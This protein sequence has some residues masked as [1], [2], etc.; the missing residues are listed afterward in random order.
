MWRTIGVLSLV[1]SGASLARADDPTADAWR[2]DGDHAIVDGVLVLGGKR[3]TRAYL[4]P[5]VQ[6]GFDICFEYRLEGKA[7]A[8]LGWDLRREGKVIPGVGLRVLPPCAD[9]DEAFA[10]EYFDWNHWQRMIKHPAGSNGVFGDVESVWLEVPA[11]SKLYLRNTRL[12]NS[13]IAVWPWIVG[14]VMSVGV[15]ALGAW[16][17]KRNTKRGSNA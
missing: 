15:S 16:R 12:Q 6:R 17:W 13:G 10:Q 8:E 4:K 9:W 5:G 2:I 3:T 1:L 11:G 7:S 14:I